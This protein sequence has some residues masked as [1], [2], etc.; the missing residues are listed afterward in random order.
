MPGRG[1]LTVTGQLGEVMRESAQAAV[2]F[3]RAAARPSGSSSRGL[4]SNPRRPHP[5][6][7]GRRAEGQRPSAGVTMAT[8][9]VSAL[10][11]RPV[12][13]DVAMTGEVTLTGQVLPIGGV[14]EKVLAAHRVRIG[15]VIL[16]KLNEDQLSQLTRTSCGEMRIELAERIEEVL[17]LALAP[18]AQAV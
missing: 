13:E 4:L 2:S 1:V 6:C 10:S 17:D 11:G 18:V 14:K 3:V 8:A 16:L 9:L 12:S 7:G 5:L 15:T